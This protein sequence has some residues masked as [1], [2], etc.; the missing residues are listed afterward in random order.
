MLLQEKSGAGP[1]AGGEPSVLTSRIGST[2][3]SLRKPG[4]LLRPRT[5]GRDLGPGAHRPSGPCRTTRVVPGRTQAE[6]SRYAG[7]AA[8]ATGAAG[9]SVVPGRGRRERGRALLPA[10]RRRPWRRSRPPARSTRVAGMVPSNPVGSQPL[11]SSAPGHR[12]SGV[13]DE[14]LG[15]QHVALERVERPLPGAE[16]LLA[17]LGHPADHAVAA[18]CRAAWRQASARPSTRSRQCRVLVTSWSTLART[19]WTRR[20]E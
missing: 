18:V 1:S 2:P 4:E 13:G 11:G 19:S 15:P 8:R 7:P 3:A 10:S 17:V 5:P 20:W 14:V 6:M 12:P 9:R 16:Q